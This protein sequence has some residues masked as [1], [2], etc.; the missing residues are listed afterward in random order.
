MSDGTMQ[1][2]L[3]RVTAEARR[4]AGTHLQMWWMGCH[5]GM[6]RRAQGEAF[7]T[8]EEHQRRLRDA[9]SARDPM[10]RLH[11]LGYRAGLAGEWPPQ[12]PHGHTGE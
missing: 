10:R 4:A 11:G 2:R 12:P 5:A 9:D 3:A 6:L 1:Q 8:E 7:G